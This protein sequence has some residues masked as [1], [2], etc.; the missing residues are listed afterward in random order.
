MRDRNKN[1]Q[2]ILIAIIIIGAVIRLIS[3][4][5]YLNMDE[6][7][8]YGDVTHFVKFHTIVPYQFFYP[9][10]FSYLALIPSI[11]GAYLLSILGI[12]SSPIEASA[13]YNLDSVLPILPIRILSLSFSIATI[14]LVFRTGKKFYDES[15]GI[16]AAAMLVFSPLDIERSSWGLPDTLMV[17]FSASAMFFCFSALKNNSLK[18]LTKA[19]IMAGL[20][21]STKY[22]A[23]MLIFPILAVAVLHLFQ[24]K[25]AGLSLGRFIKIMLLSS[26]AFVCAFLLASPGWMIVPGKF[27]DTFR[28]LHK[29]MA[30]G[31]LGFFG[32]PYIQYIIL[33]FQSEKTISIMFAVGIICA[34][35]RRNREDI[36]FL[37]LFLP[38]FLYIGSWER[39]S[40]NYLMFLWPSLA[41]ISAYPISKF[42][43][44]LFQKKRTAIAIVMI[45]ALF[46]WPMYSSIRYA[47]TQLLEDSR[48]VTNRW[49]QE[50]LPEGSKVVVD[51]A[52]VPRILNMDQKK[53][54]LDSQLFK[55]FYRKRLAQWRA[56]EKIS[57]Q[58]DPIWVASIKADFLI[59]SSSCFSRFFN[60]P[61]PRSKSP[62]RA[63]FDARKRTY[64]FLLKNEKESG[65]IL[66]KDFYTG[67]GPHILVYKRITPTNI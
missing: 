66:L 47:C 61:S 14:W 31:S 12:I 27:L 28:S 32:L 2:R 67:K 21:T 62:L 18:N 43:R 46:V 33:M 40:L 24:T 15:V 50:N 49:I 54:L 56:Y 53:E 9:T 52:Y 58:Y 17:L 36:V 23:G 59:T 60:T 4:A 6:K 55:K 1:F 65:W 57:L 29:N 34:V 26:A 30:E 22:N 48:W 41:V 13:L 5:K 42:I 11:I 8:I 37:C 3:C 10:F 51:W 45:S 64:E 39:K 16:L 35:I 25:K 7:L 44:S 20:A 38:S 19:S 63:E